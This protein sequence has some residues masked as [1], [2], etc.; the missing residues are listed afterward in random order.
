MRLFDC[1]IAVL[2]GECSCAEAVEGMAFS[3]NVFTSVSPKTNRDKIT[4]Q[5]LILSKLLM[6]LGSTFRIETC[7]TYYPVDVL[8]DSMS[9]DIYPDQ[10]AD[11]PSMALGV[12]AVEPLRALI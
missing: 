9:S 11:E 8:F 7:D 3:S 1:P 4:F 10:R 12:W 6:H 5:L 2:R